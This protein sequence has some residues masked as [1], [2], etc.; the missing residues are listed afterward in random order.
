[1]ITWT[2]WLWAL[3]LAF[4][5]LWAA[6]SLAIAAFRPWRHFTGP[7]WWISPMLIFLWPGVFGW[8]ALELAIEAYDPER[9]DGG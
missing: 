8:M 9:G 3:L 5:I 7:D 4:A 6:G 2:D 1:M